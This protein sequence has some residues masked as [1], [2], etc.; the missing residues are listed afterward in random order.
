MSAN[1]ARKPDALAVPSAVP[2]PHFTRDLEAK[3][4]HLP[5]GRVMGSTLDATYGP[6]GHLWVLTQPVDN[7][8]AMLPHVAEFD[9][10]GTFVGAWGGPDSVARVSGVSQ[11]PDGSEGIEVDGGKQ[12]LD[13]RLQGRRPCGPEVLPPRR[14]AAAVRRARGAGR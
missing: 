1:V 14:A 8:A 13:F 2:R 9:A 12:C 3:L 6:D 7:N 5:A 11:W 4:F 10:N